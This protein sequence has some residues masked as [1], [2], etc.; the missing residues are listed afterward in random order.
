VLVKVVGGHAFHIIPISNVCR[1]IRA[2]DEESVARLAMVEL[3]RFVQLNE[4]E[5]PLLTVLDAPGGHASLFI[6][7]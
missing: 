4:A 7:E 5:V 6:E 1:H 2:V 3:P